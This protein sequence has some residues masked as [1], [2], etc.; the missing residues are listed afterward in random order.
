MLRGS[1]DLRPWLRYWHRCAP[2]DRSVGAHAGRLL[3]EGA[4]EPPKPTPGAEEAMGTQFP[5]DLTLPPAATQHAAKVGSMQHEKWP[6]SPQVAL[7]LAQG[8]GSE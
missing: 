7:M 5:F 2:G 3:P 6:H 4:F 1:H 8:Q